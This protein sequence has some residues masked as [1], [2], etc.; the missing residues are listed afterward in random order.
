M[1][2]GLELRVMVVAFCTA[3]TPVSDSISTELRYHTLQ[4]ADACT[5][6]NKQTNKRDSGLAQH[7]RR[8]WRDE[9]GSR[10]TM[11]SEDGLITGALFEQLS[12]RVGD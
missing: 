6:T 12:S 10:F 7:L 2:G 4:A 8:R 3:W 11:F 9:E 5:Q 1:G